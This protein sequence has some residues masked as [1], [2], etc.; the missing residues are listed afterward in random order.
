M[1]GKWDE[2]TL[3]KCNLC[4]EYDSRSHR[5]TSCEATRHV[6][7][8]FP[9][10]I[11]LLCNEKEDWIYL[12]LSTYRDDYVVFRGVVEA[13]KLPEDFPSPEISQ[14]HHVYFTD[15]GC[16]HPTVAEARLASWSVVRD[17]AENPAHACAMT[18][19]A[20]QTQSPCPLLRP[21]DMGMV[22]GIQTISRG[23]LCAVIIACK[24]ALKDHLMTQTSI[25]TDSKYVV[26]VVKFLESGDL[27]HLDYKIANIDLVRKL[28]SVW[29]AKNSP[30]TRSK[31]MLIGCQ[32]KV[33][34]QHV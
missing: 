12:P 30:S 27:S 19:I 23:E 15:G 10:A 5:L 29:D 8:N 31:V 34:N 17:F 11:Q 22:E 9:Q 26:N 24:H 3:T 20:V 16:T 25:F 6:R 32:K 33:S 2:E 13:F 18:S 21:I 28:K 7:E 4:D 14:N 1:K